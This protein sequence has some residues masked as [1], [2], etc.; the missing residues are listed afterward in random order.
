MKIRILVVV[1]T[2]VVFALAIAAAQTTPQN[3][4][5]KTKSRWANASRFACRPSEGVMTSWT[6]QRGIKDHED[7]Q[8]I[9]GG[10]LMLCRAVSAPNTQP[11]PACFVS[12]QHN[13]P[14]TIPSHQALRA[15]DNDDVITLGCNGTT[16]T[17]CQLQLVPPSAAAAEKN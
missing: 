11:D 13:G 14:Y 6:G 5:F 3:K 9:R 15:P 7:S 16:P 1:Y 17:C 4:P 12:F 10:S 8:T 2:I